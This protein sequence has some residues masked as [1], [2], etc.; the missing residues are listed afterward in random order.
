[1]PPVRPSLLRLVSLA[2]IVLA[3]LTTSP[4]AQQRVGIN[5]A[6]N[7]DATGK[8][9]GAQ[10]RRLVIGGDVVFNEHI[11][12]SDGGQTQLLFLDQSAMT[13]GPNSEV[14]IDEFVYDP[15][16]GTGKLAMSATQGV[17]RFIGGKLSKNDN[18]VT[19]TTPQGLSR[20]AAGSFLPKSAAK[21]CWSFSSMAR[22]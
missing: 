2:G 13:I 21:A 12:T 9:P 16:S 22:V 5:S 18:A 20:C 6:V 19:F 15:K 10:P 3:G 8:P 14:T 4:G 7:P 1:M 17:L 11:T